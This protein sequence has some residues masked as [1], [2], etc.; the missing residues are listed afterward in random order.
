MSNIYDNPSGFDHSDPEKLKIPPIYQKKDE[1]PEIKYKN[2]IFKPNHLFQLQFFIL[3]Q[4]KTESL[5][6]ESK[7]EYI[8][9]ETDLRQLLESFKSLFQK[10]MIEN[11]SHDYLFAD[12]LS[13]NWHL[14][15][16]IIQSNEKRRSLPKHLSLLQLFIKTV[17]NYPE[18][19]EHTLGFYLSEYTGEKWIPFP[20]MDLLLNLHEDALLKKNKS[21]LNNWVLSISTIISDL[22]I[23]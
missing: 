13:K 23:K 10:L 1:A 19:T 17:Q 14:L 20:F 11:I 22:R 15:L 6:E 21:I 18:N 16:K 9:I 7:L 12:A 4:E 8:T 5:L 2:M 3:L